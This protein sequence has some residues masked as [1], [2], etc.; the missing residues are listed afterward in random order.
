[1]FFESWLVYFGL[2][3]HLLHLFVKMPKLNWETGV[4]INHIKFTMGTDSIGIDS[5]PMGGA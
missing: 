1:M 5:V 3:F 4:H 2:F